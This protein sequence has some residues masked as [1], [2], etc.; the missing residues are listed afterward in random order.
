[1]ITASPHSGS[2]FTRARAEHRKHSK[3]GSRSALNARSPHPPSRAKVAPASTAAFSLAFLIVL[4]FAGAAAACPACKD[5]VSDNPDSARLTRGF[6]RSIYVLMAT[7]YLLFGGV[8]F[9]IVRS[10]RR[11]KQANR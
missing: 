8:T 2:G 6:A 1:M 4:L 11:S 7:P 10:A 5:A 3:A 9:A